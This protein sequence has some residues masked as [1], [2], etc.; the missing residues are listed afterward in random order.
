MRDAIVSAILK[1]TRERGIEAAI[2]E[3]AKQFTPDELQ[4]IREGDP[5]VNRLLAVPDKDAMMLMAKG[6]AAL[7]QEKLC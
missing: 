6:L 1:A 4:E 7:V 5:A 3:F 2:G